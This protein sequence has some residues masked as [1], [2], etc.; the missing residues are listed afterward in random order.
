MVAQQIQVLGNDFRV[1]TRGGN[2]NVSIDTPY[3]I[4]LV[5]LF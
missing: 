3:F 2:T 4:G 5:R 1:K